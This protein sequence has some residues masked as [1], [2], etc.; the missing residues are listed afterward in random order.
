METKVCAQEWH[1]A[2]I[3]SCV[4]CACSAVEPGSV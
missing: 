4:E 1:Q 3:A 2:C